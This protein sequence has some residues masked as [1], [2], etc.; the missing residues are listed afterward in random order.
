[1]LGCES[2]KLRE[3]NAE[4]RNST[5][6]Q[7]SSSSRLLL[8]KIAFSIRLATCSSTVEGSDAFQL[9]VLVQF[10]TKPMAD[11]DHFEVNGLQL[12]SRIYTFAKSAN[13]IRLASLICSM[14]SASWTAGGRNLQ[15]N[16]YHS[17][18]AQPKAYA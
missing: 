8:N 11:P 7:R 17:S 13:D 2:I 18:P 4:K 6:S 9:V 1:M 10:K 5:I 16:S 12:G 3:L 14:H 15:S